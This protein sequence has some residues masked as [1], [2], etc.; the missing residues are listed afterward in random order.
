LLERGTIAE[1]PDNPPRIWRSKK[2]PSS[3][4]CSPSK[5]DA[6]CDHRTSTKRWLWRRVPRRELARP[7]VIVLSHLASSGWLSSRS[8]RGTLCELFPTRQG[9]FSFSPS[10]LGRV[11]DAKIVAD[12]VCSRWLHRDV[13]VAVL[14]SLARVGSDQ[15]NVRLA[16]GCALR[17]RSSILVYCVDYRC[18]QQSFDVL[19]ADRWSDEVR[20]SDVKARF[21]CKA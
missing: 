16:N 6:A 15:S 8:D 18:N 10:I 5:E 13:W 21:V 19:S 14:L 11:I 3:D 9:F 17:G 20:L 7:R 4:R 1:W 12:L 2:E